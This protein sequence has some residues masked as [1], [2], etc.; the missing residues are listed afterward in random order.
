MQKEFHI[1]KFSLNEVHH[2]NEI[3][4]VL[5]FWV[6]LE[7]STCWIVR[8]YVDEGL[9]FNNIAE[10]LNRSN[11]TPLTQIRKHNN[12]LF[13]FLRLTRRQLEYHQSQGVY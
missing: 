1:S 9:G 12:P 8:L 5:T 7:V 6:R 10:V 13:S 11:R 2:Q 4:L 3:I